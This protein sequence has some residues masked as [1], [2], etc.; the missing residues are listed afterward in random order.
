MRWR[1]YDEAIELL[2]QRFQYLPRV[3]RWRGRRYSVEVVRKCW[4]TSRWRWRGRVERRFFQ[5]QCAEGGF[6]LFQ[7]L[8]SGT[9]RL[10]RARFFSARALAVRRVSPAW[11]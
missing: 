5:V 6:E 8:R 4:T 9:W 1:I 7:D 3:F 11:W 10:R 2:E